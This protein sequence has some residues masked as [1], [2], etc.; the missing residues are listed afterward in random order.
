MFTYYGWTLG[1]WQEAHCFV[2]GRDLPE[3]ARRDIGA[4]ACGM[5]PEPEWTEVMAE[6]WKRRAY[7]PGESPLILEGV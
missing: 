6:W 1:Q 3:S 4:H 2:R 7:A 5:A